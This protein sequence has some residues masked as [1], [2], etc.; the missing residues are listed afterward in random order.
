MES[1]WSLWLVVEVVRGGLRNR[2]V[3]REETEAIGSGSRVCGVMEGQFSGGLY[4]CNNAIKYLKS[5]RN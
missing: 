2:Q 1:L 4:Q 5:E 3:S